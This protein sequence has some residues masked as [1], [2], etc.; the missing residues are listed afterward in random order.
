MSAEETY[1]LLQSRDHEIRVLRA[2]VDALEEEVRQARGESAHEY[3]RA[4]ADETLSQLRF[5][6]GLRADKR[7]R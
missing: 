2:Y 3:A 5:E 4:N 1:S 7:I 6:H